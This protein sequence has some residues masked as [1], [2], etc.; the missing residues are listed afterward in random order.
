[1]PA[2]RA[3]FVYSPL[4][5][6]AV[7][8]AAKVAELAQGQGEV[9]EAIDVDL[10]FDVPSSKW[11][12]RVGALVQ[13]PSRSVFGK[14]IQAND[15][16]KLELADKAELAPA[17]NAAL[18]EI[19]IQVKAGGKTITAT[20]LGSN[21]GSNTGAKAPNGNDPVSESYAKAIA[22]AAEAA[23]LP[24]EYVTRLKAEAEILQRVQSFGRQH[25][26]SNS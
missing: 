5:D 23:R 3:Y 9:A 8:S 26:L 19:Q 13:R 17:A 6:P 16:S 10:V 25:G 4:I 11:N 12:G 21:T 22:K 15:L 1:M 24:A 18:K 20:A 7:A 14:L 2:P